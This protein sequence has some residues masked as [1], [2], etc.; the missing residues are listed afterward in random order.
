MAMKI[1]AEVFRDIVE[2]VV[3]NVFDEKQKID[4][5]RPLLEMFI[6]EYQCKNI[7]ECYGVDFTLDELLDDYF[8]KE[9]DDDDDGLEEEF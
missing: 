4:I 5:L 7:E 8:E 1:D 9:E 6:E 3:D 2:L